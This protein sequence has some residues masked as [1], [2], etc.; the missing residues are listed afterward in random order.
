M[1]L[2]STQRTDGRRSSERVLMLR[3]NEVK[4]FK[5]IWRLKEANLTLSTAEAEFCLARSKRITHIFSNL[6]KRG[7]ELI[8]VLEAIEELPSTRKRQER[9]LRD[10]KMCAKSTFFTHL[11]SK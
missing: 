9:T 6:G 8:G 11:V 1:K 10:P 2:T 3:G 5:G 4:G 7:T